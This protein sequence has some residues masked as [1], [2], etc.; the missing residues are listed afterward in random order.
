M[1]GLPVVLPP[2]LAAQAMLQWESDREQRVGVRDSRVVGAGAEGDADLSSGEEVPYR[3]RRVDGLVGVVVT[4]QIAAGPEDPQVPAG[5]V[6]DP[7]GQSGRRVPAL[8]DVR[9][10]VPVEIDQR[11]GAETAVG[12]EERP[13]RKGGP[14]RGVKG[15][16]VLAQRRRYHRIHPTEDPGRRRCLHT[17]LSVQVGC[18]PLPQESSGVTEGVVPAHRGLGGV[19]GIDEDGI[20]PE[21]VQRGRRCRVDGPSGVGRPA[22]RCGPIGEVER[23]EVATAI[24]HHDRRSAAVQCGDRRRALGD[25][26]PAVGEVLLPGQRDGERRMDGRGRCNPRPCHR[27]CSESQKRHDPSESDARTEE[28]A[29]APTRSSGPGGR[30]LSLDPVPEFAPDVVAYL[31]PITLHLPVS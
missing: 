15:V 20:G 8:D 3:R 16:L 22:R 24:A 18:T 27:R 1:A 11:R 29:S 5:R 25:R 2:R 28:T 13:A 12:G 23:P 26:G 10:T 19:P 9:L 4:D 30:V 31:H 6:V 7:V 14:V 21:S 17:V